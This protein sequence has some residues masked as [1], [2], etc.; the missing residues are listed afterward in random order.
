MAS[1]PDPPPGLDLTE[2]NVPRFVASTSLTWAMAVACVG[3]R[4]WARKLTRSGFWWDDWIILTSIIWTG[5]FFFTATCYIVPRGLGLHIWAAPPGAM[6]AYFFGLYIVEFAYVLALFSVKSSILALYWR[7]FSADRRIRWP[8]MILF[9]ISL[10]WAVA[11]IVVILL[12]CQPISAFWARFDVN[13]PDPSE[14]NCGV[15]LHQFFLGNSIPNILTDISLIVVP[16]PFIWKLSLL[17][18]QKIAILGIFAVG[19]FVTIVS[20]VRLH[21]I[22]NLD[23]KNPDVIWLASQEMNW[24]ITEIN[25][26]VICAC[27]PSLKPILNLILRGRLHSTQS[28]NSQGL[29]D[30]SAKDG[31]RIDLSRKWSSNLLLNPAAKGTSSVSVSTSKDI[32]NDTHPFAKLAGHELETWQYTETTSTG[33]KTSGTEVEGVEES[34]SH[35]I[36]VTKTIR[37][38]TQG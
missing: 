19:L 7:I 11:L 9:S 18:S 28:A 2:T 30:S 36:I 23:F 26:A 35:G 16:T 1:L 25:V 34:V 8:L 37:V 33:S 17:H 12:Q 10:T 15:N 20:V 24:T 6:R 38:K 22:L 3:M 32:H 29:H 21:F 4:F 5:I 31:S 27:L 14:Y 13:P